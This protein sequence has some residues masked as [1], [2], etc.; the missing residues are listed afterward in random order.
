MIFDK[1]AYVPA[2]DTIDQQSL[3]Q[4]SYSETGKKNH[5]QAHQKEK[6]IRKRKH[7][8]QFQTSSQT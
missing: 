4:E 1:N 3:V 8:T 7:L 6:T 2:D 5:D